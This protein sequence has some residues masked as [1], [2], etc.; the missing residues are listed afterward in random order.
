MNKYSIITVIAIIVII[1]PILYGLWSIYAVEQLQVRTPNS[2][3]RYF[4]MSNDEKIQLCNPLPFFVSFNGLKISTYY[5]D[6]LK[7]EFELGQTKIE[8]QISE[9]IEGNFYSENFSESQY[10]LLHMDWEFYDEGAIR[11]DPSKMLVITNF[12]TKIIGIIPYQT[13]ITQSGFEFIQMMNE[14]SKCGNSD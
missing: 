10:F 7:G 9:V 3:F 11:L 12:E 1:I 5:A 2:E 14:D 13:T 4:E 6:E 8:P